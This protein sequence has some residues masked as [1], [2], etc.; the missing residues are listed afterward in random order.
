MLLKCLLFSY[1]FYILLPTSQNDNFREIQSRHSKS[2]LGE[3]ECQSLLQLNQYQRSWVSTHTHF[4]KWF[5]KGFKPYAEMSL[6]L[7]KDIYSVVR[8][9]SLYFKFVFNDFRERGR[10]LRE[11]HGWAASCTPLTGDQAHNPGHMS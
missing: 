1:C 10:E 3:R 4:L 8:E 2:A 7:V 5:W 11:K 6:I 9:T